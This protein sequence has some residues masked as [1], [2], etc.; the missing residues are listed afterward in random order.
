MTESTLLASL[1]EAGQMFGNLRSAI[2]DLAITSSLT[3]EERVSLQ[4]V[5]KMDT[6]RS[7]SGCHTPTGR[8]DY[9]ET[10][11]VVEQMVTRLKVIH[12]FPIAVSVIISAPAVPLNVFCSEGLRTSQ[13]TAMLDFATQ[14]VLLGQSLTNTLTKESK[15]GG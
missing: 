15:N 14:L 7:V 9:K 13:V 5:V 8:V 6:F 3:P 11:K 10:A 4:T 1:I 2:N 12:G